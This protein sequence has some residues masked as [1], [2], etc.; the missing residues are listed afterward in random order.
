MSWHKTFIIHKSGLAHVSIVS[1]HLIKEALNVMGIGEK[2]STLF[3]IETLKNSY[4]LVLHTMSYTNSF[5][6]FCLRFHVSPFI[7]CYE[8]KSVQT[9]HYS[10]VIFSDEWDWRVN[11]YIDLTSHKLFKL[12]FDPMHILVSQLWSKVTII[13]YK[14]FETVVTSYFN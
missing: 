7:S 4:H 13:T 9:F 2:I 12:M 14:L 8:M 3:D 5:K 6:S 10:L 1:K 11:F